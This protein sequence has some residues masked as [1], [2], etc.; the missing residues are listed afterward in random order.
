[1]GL[2]TMGM[3]CQDDG[4]MMMSHKCHQE[5]DEEEMRF[6]QGNVAGGLGRKGHRQAMGVPR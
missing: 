1:M 3:E 5:R 4:W 6:S 2:G